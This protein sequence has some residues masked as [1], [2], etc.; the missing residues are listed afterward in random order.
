MGIFTWD[1]IKSL[2]LVFQLNCVRRG[3]SGLIIPTPSECNS[4]NRRRSGLPEAEITPVNADPHLGSFS[5]TV[6][7]PEQEFFCDAGR[8]S[9]VG[10]LCAGDLNTNQP[11]VDR[12]TGLSNSPNPH[13]YRD[14]PTTKAW[15]FA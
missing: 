9:S 6:E 7:L 11:V 8:L 13:S 2:G 10:R 5:R 12:I 14:G 15:T 1:Q 4:A 3:H